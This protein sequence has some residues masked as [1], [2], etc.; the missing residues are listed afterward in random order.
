[1]NKLILFDIDGTLFEKESALHKMAFS[2]AFKKIFGIDTTIDIIDHPGKT[3]KQIVV[4]V[5]KKKGL[6]ESDV[7]GKMEEITKEM[8]SFFEERAGKERITLLEG[9]KELLD[10]LKSKN[11]LMGLVTGNLE[12]IARAKLKKGDINDYFKLGGFGSDGERR[13]DLIRIAIKKA[14]DSFDFKFN[15][16]VFLVGDTQRDIEAGKEAGIKTIGVETGAYSEE[17][18]K[19]TGADFVFKNLKNKNKILE[20]IQKNE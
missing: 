10:E 13:A 9:V 11:I 20:L 19:E 14:E 2:A 8:I 17:Q 18:L 3:D 1:M 15:N 7:R 12:R 4:E 5:L 6:E 16:N